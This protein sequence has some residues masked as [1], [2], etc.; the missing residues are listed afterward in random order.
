MAERNT[1]CDTGSNAAENGLG[2]HAN[3]LSG[4]IAITNLGHVPSDCF[5]IPVLDDGEQPDFAIQHR[6]DLRGV[7]APH[8]VRRIGGDVPVM[9]FTWPREAAVRRQQAVLAHQ[10]Q[11]SLAGNPKP[12]ENAQPR[13]TLR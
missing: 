4:C 12:I 10:P 8:Q 13:P 3:G 11:H 2:C 6:R 1:T 7:G 9:G 5:G